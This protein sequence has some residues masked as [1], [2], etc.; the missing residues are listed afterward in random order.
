[1]DLCTGGELIDRISEYG[2]L[3]EEIA[4]SIFKQMVESVNYCNSLEVYHRDLTPRSFMFLRNEPNTPLILVDLGISRLVNS[5]KKGRSLT[6]AQGDVSVVFSVALLYLP[7]TN[8]RRNV[9][10]VQHVV[11]RCHPLLNDN[12]SSSFHRVK[13]RKDPCSREINEVLPRPYP[14]R[15]S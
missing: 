5:G 8:Q 14:F 10:R 11:P 2:N 1:M 9:P 6:Q 13:Q 7:R 12:G 15:N 3:S 4:A